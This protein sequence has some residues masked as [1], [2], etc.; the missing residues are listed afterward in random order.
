MTWD[1]IEAV[2]RD[3]YAGKYGNGSKR[4]QKLAEEGYDPTLVQKM[5]NY[6][7][8]NGAKPEIVEP[9]PP[10]ATDTITV[11]IDLKKHK[12]VVFNFIE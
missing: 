8:Y 4:K 7:F 10:Q 5:V 9:E 6:L 11:D 12:K 2:A 3:V 1:T